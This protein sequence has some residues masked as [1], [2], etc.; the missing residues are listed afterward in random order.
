MGF[1][2]E[3][4]IAADDRPSSLRSRGHSPLNARSFG[5]QA[6]GAGGGTW[7]TRGMPGFV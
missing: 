5:R 3:Q 4:G 6:E 2:A 7:Q 1:A